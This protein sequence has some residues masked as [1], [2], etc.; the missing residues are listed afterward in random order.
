M[1]T[2]SAVKKMKV[3]NSYV[4]GSNVMRTYYVWTTYVSWKSTILN[5]VA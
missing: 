2:V 3:G 4:N 1:Y 5:E